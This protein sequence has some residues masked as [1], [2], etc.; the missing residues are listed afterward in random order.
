MNEEK[1]HLWRD[2]MVRDQ[3]QARG[4]NDPRVLEVFR[5]V[6]RHLFVPEHWRDESYEDHPVSIGESQTISQPYMVALM[7]QC[8]ELQ[9]NE[10][11]LEIGSGSGYQ[12]AILAELCS[13]VVTIERIGLLSTRAKEILDRLGYKN[14]TF[15][16]GDGTLGVPEFAPYDRILVTASAPE[17]PEPLSEQLVEGG[18]MVLPVGH[19]FMQELII[20]RRRGREL[21]RKFECRCVFVPLLGMY[22]FPERD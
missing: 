11:V 13:Q 3:L 5:R 4:I 19:G 22:G 15:R 10:K 14:V 17:I 6:P 18:M 2:A 7:T 12:T 9:G 20:A 8:L 16:V 21:S 1:L